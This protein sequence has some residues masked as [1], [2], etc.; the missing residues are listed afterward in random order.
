MR[1]RR[2]D[3][4]RLLPRGALP[5]SDD[6]IILSGAMENPYI[7]GNPIGDPSGFFGRDDVF[8][9]VEQVL[10]RR[11]SNAIVLYGQRRI[12]KTSVLLQL[13]RRLAAEALGTPVF[14]DL[15]DKAALP[16]GQLV[17]DLAQRIAAVTKQPAPVRSEFDEQG[18][19]FCTTFLPRVAQAVGGR[20][21]VLLFDEFDVLDAPAQAHA[22]QAFFPYLRRWMAAL[23]RVA[24]VFVIGR[25]SGRSLRRDVVDVQG[26]ARHARRPARSPQRDDARSTIAG[27]RRR[28]AVE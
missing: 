8:R 11:A 7:A 12:G 5:S 2:A 22:G 23:E 13:E 15:Q 6:V 14:L 10:R 17:F 27:E 24:F 18:E 28:P 25:A 20:G 3:R 9:A 16:L 4:K 1:H 26:C 21:L 19:Y